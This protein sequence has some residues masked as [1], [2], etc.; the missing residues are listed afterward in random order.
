[1]SLGPFRVDLTPPVTGLVSS[2]THL[3]GVPSSAGIVTIAWPAAGDA[4]SGVDGFSFVWDLSQATEPDTT[5]EAE[6]T[7]SFA[8][9]P[10]L[11]A[12]TYWFHIR[13]RDNAG[14]WSPTTTAGPF[15]ITLP[16]LPPVTIP[17]TRTATPTTPAARVC[18]VPRVTKKTLKAAK[19]AIVKADCS[20]GRV[21]RAA[22]NRV[23]A[24]RVISQSP[25]A[26]QRR[27]AGAKVSLVVSRGRRR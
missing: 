13:T 24:G 12:G 21:K 2:P 27:P 14:N 15:V 8:T 23:K 3:T 17:T 11:G 22:S 1:V 19:A 16:V 10:Q 26:G 7:A 4:T 18:R 20:T 5:K 6:E 9:S 25:K